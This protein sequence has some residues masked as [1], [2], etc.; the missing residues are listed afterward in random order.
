MGR[1]GGLTV[2]IIFACLAG[3]LAAQ[4][5]GPGRGIT[6][7]LVAISIMA[8][9][10][11]WLGRS[12]KPYKPVRERDANGSC[13]W[14]DWP[15]RWLMAG[16]LAGVASMAAGALAAAIL[17]LATGNRVMFALF[18]VLTAW[19]LAGSWSLATARRARTAAILAILSVA[20]LGGAAS[21]LV[22]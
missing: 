18:V 10:A 2:A 8:A 6:W 20:G 12:T 16:P 9:I 17:P 7:V 1:A 21:G 5:L 15:I 19:G 4:G 14:P 11:L 3:I 13:D 22:L